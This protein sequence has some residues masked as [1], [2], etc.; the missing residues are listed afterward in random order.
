ME[1]IV[2]AIGGNAIEN[3]EILKKLTKD[4]SEIIKRGYKVLITHGNGLQVGNLLLQQALTS[5]FIPPLPLYMLIGI[6][7]AE[8][9]YI[10]QHYLKKYLPNK[11]IVTILT[12]V[13]VSKNDLAFKN[14]SKPIGPPF[15]REEIESIAKKFGYEIKKTT[16]KEKE[17]Y[18][19]VVPSPEPIKII[20]EDIIKDLFKKEVILIAGGGGG[21]PVIINEKGEL[22]SINCV[23]D[24]DFTAQLLAN[25]IQASTLLIITNVKKVKL[26]F[27]KE[28][29]KEISIMNLSEAK[30]YL[31]EG[32]FLEGSMKPKI[33]ASIRFLENGGE[34]VIITSHENLM[35]AIDGK[36]GTIIT[37]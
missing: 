15:T 4:I 17:V 25:L 19:I 11:N 30:K 1:N 21:I 34:K 14:P 32:Q 37:R 7:Q 26:N 20:E 18:R 12:Q 31:E 6:T 8:I 24:K 35:E 3:M 2:I 10:I 22:E 13:L 28:N 5:E 23:V 36:E 16:F 33:L 9:G 27:M 29:E